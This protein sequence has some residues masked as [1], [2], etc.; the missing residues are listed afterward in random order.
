MPQSFMPFNLA[1]KDFSTIKQPNPPTEWGTCTLFDN[2]PH[3]DNVPHSDKCA[4]KI[5]KP[6]H[7]GGKFSCPEFP[8][9]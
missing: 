9:F 6:E 1:Q 2:I 7:I 8:C 5:Q 4:L 3:S